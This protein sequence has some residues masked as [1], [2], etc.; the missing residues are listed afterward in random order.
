M[1]VIGLRA[2][3][4]LRFHT[5]RTRHLD[6]QAAEASEKGVYRE[7]N[8]D[9]TYCNP[10]LGI[11]VI[12]DGMGGY[13]GG[14]A[15]SAIVVD[16]VSKALCQLVLNEPVSTSS[17]ESAAE[18]AIRAAIREYQLFAKHVP[19]FE[20][21]GCT[22]ALAVAHDNNLFYGRIGD[23]R[24]YHMR[25]RRCVSLLRD[26]TLVQSLVK[27]GTMTDLEARASQLR[28][29]VLN[30]V[31]L[32]N[33]A[34]CD[35]YRL[36]LVAGD[37]VLLTTDGLSNEF[38]CRDLR[39]FTD[40]PRDVQAVADLLVTEALDRGSRDNASCVFVRFS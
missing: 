24:I 14:C 23:G 35:I 30:C 10:S 8:E 19:S 16:R 13:D 4:F 20:R 36:R 34:Q 5:S 1:A 26:E 22:L 38:D 27:A 9:H 11:F 2:N 29:V 28:G 15:A 6:C 18:A 17:V 21:M 39:A 31:S 32:R 3:R 12:A 37:R 40:S 25:G 33:P 7:E